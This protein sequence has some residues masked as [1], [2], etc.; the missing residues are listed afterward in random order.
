MKNRE[1]SN[2][3]APRSISKIEESALF[4]ICLVLIFSI[5]IFGQVFFDSDNFLGVSEYMALELKSNEDQLKN[6]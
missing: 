6:E 4:I 1:Y 3:K 2:Y 5:G